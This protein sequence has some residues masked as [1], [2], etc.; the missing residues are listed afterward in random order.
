MRLVVTLFLQQSNTVKIEA[1][2]AVDTELHLLL[3][4]LL[5]LF[6]FYAHWYFIPRALDWTYYLILRC[7]DKGD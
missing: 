6:T 5:L 7:K 1:A 3:L 4:L 2:L